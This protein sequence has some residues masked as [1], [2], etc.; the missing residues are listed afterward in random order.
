MNDSPNERARNRAAARW[1]QVLERTNVGDGSFVY[2]VR[3][4]KIYCRP[5]CPS[6]RPLRRNVEFFET[7]ER[8]GAAGYRPCRRCRPDLEVP[9]ENWIDR[10]CRALEQS[11]SRRKARR[12]RNSRC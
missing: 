11:S 4:T 1:Q 3:T 6:R 8:A 10:V 12:S 5:T 2:E 7:R 9:D